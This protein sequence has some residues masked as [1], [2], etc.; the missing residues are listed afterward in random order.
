[1]FRLHH[2]N[3][4]T[5]DVPGLNEFYKRALPLEQLPL[6]HLHQDASGLGVSFLSAGDPE[7]LQVHIASQRIDLGRELGHYVNPV[8]RGHIAFR[9]DDIKAIMARLDRVGVHYSDY[10]EWAVPGWHQIYFKDPLGNV[11]EVQQNLRG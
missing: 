2:V 5:Q 7:W 11:I 10:G 1:M 3:I 9:C 4:T 6:P 8:E